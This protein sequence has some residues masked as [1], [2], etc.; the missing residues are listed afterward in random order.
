MPK[1]PVHNLDISAGLHVNSHVAYETDTDLSGIEKDDL[2][3]TFKSVFETI[4]ATQHYDVYWN[5]AQKSQTG[6]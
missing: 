6:E 2:L 5:A 1:K 4:G 3:S